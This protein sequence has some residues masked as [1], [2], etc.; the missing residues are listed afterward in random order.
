MSPERLIQVP[1]LVVVVQPDSDHEQVL[2]STTRRSQYSLPRS[3]VFSLDKQ[4]PYCRR[5]HRLVPGVL[6]RRL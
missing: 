6:R 5:S 1:E 2:P 3:T 4:P